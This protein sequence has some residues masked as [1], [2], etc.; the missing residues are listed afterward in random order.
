MDGFVEFPGS[1]YVELWLGERSREDISRAE[2]GS[3]ERNTDRWESLRDASQN[4]P[5]KQ[6]KKKGDKVM[7][8]PNQ[9]QERREI[10]L[11]R[12]VTSNRGD[13]AWICRKSPKR[14]GIVA[15]GDSWFAYPQRL[16][17]GDANVVDH[18]AAQLTRRNKTNLLQLASIGDTAKEMLSG[19][20]KD[21]LESVLKKNAD[22]VRLILFSG[23]G[24]DI[25]GESN[26]LP[27]LNKYQKG[28]KAR[29]CIKE[30][31][32]RKK[33]DEITQAYKT[34][35]ELRD[36]Y[37]PTAKIV[38]H[39]YDIPQPRNQGAEFL[40]GLIEKGPWIYPALDEK[41][42]PDDL[43]LSIAEV[44]LQSFRQRL[45]S[46]QEES[47]GKIFVA[48]TQGTLQP[49]NEDDWQ[50]EIHPT[51]IGFRRIAKVIYRLMKTVEPGLPAWRN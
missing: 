23:G 39:V 51:G 25:V 16:S 11:H 47:A 32:L 35:I 45:L 3:R 24:N 43:H 29:D 14:I 50:D 5:G 48:D 37:V 36:Q 4:V 15:E 2:H 8:A 49:G 17:G 34:L 27:L 38:T 46:L 30:E 21:I 22:Y 28:F 10:A 40:L 12:G 1:S 19:R 9:P 13:F 20:Q 33:L 7:A 44:L 41:C 26:L 18:I 42:I 6:L 31:A